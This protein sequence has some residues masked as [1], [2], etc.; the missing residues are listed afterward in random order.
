[1]VNSLLGLEN[2]IVVFVSKA[3]IL[4]ETVVFTRP[5]LFYHH[6]VNKL[7]GNLSETYTENLQRHKVCT[8]IYIH[9]H[10][11]MYCFFWWWGKE[12]I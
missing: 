11:Y 9:I 2:E 6:L 5:I 10:M 7:I 8:F 4:E 3:N 12:D 1:M